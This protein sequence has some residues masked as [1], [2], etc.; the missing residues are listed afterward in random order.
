MYCPNCG[1]LLTVEERGDF[2]CP[3]GLEFSIALSKR[4]R[5]LY[6]TALND[7][8]DPPKLDGTRKWFCPSCGALLDISGEPCP[9]CSSLLTGDVVYQMVEIHPHPNGKGGFF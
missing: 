3:N 6:P 5:L 4:L 1:G 8:I 7:P 9:K 2:V